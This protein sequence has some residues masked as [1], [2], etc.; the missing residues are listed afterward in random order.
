MAI[1]FAVANGVWSN[2]ATWNGGTLPTSADDIFAN[3]FTV[4]VDQDITAITLRNTSN[5]SPAITQGGQ[6]VVTGNT[7]TRNVTLTGTRQS[8]S[9][10][11]SGLWQATSAA[12]LFEVTATSGLTLNLISPAGQ[13]NTNIGFFVSIVGNCT[14]NY[15]GIMNQNPGF[16]SQFNV[17]AGASNGT[18]T[19]VGNPIGNG[20]SPTR[21]SAPGYTVN[22]I[23][24]LTNDI[25]EI[26]AAATV[27]VTGNVTGGAGVPITWNGGSGGVVNI[28]GNVTAATT[29]G[30]NNNSTN[31]TIVVNGNVT[32]SSTAN[33]ILINT[34][35]SLVTVNGNLTNV[36]DIT[37]V[38]STRLRIS[39]SSQQAWTFQTSGP[40]RQIFTANAFSGG[41]VPA[42]SDVRLG[43][44]YAG[45]S[46]SGT[47]A[48]PSANSVAFGVPVDNTTGTS[49]IT[50]AQFLT[51]LGTI[52]AGYPQI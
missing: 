7:G 41:T 22:I 46:L 29:A 38:Y 24:N 26:R 17:A 13:P 47:C 16:F 32:A 30:I 8:V 1:R 5:V 49:L 19:M 21:I 14:I 33:G 3:N 51:D 37:A 20:N 42:A 15:S 45:G 12:I 18:L 2:T 48:V 25:L 31:Q 9:F 43:V 11:N 10:F 44:S 34:V 6:F 36:A 50:R 52:A 23:G 35:N 28:T 39:P 40:N 4:T 27:N